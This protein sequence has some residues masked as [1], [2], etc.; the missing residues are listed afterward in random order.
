MRTIHPNMKYLMVSAFLA[1]GAYLC[2]FA[3]R[4]RRDCM[5][6][7]ITGEA[8]LAASLLVVLGVSLCLFAVYILLF[9]FW[10]W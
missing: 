10:S 9:D 6:R 1:V 3:W 2:L 5:N 4:H 8:L 7:T